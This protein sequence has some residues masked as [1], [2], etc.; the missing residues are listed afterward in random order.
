MK[1]VSTVLL[2]AVF[3]L[4]QFSMASAAAVAGD[5][6]RYHVGMRAAEFPSVFPTPYKSL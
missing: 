1:K 6:C 5:S 3:V 4:A 2:L